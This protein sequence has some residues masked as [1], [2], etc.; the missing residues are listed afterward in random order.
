[1]IY[2]YGLD[3][4]K[5]HAIIIG[6]LMSD[7]I[8]GIDPGKTG[9]FAIAHPGEGEEAKVWKLPM[10][11]EDIISL[12]GDYLVYDAFIEKVHA[13]PKQGVVSTFTFGKEVGKWYGLLEAIG[14]E[15]H[16][17][18]PKTWQ[19]SCIP[20]WIHEAHE[21]PKERSLAAAKWIYPK[22]SDSIGRN[23]NKS[24]SL[25]IATYGM[26]EVDFDKENNKV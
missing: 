9:A 2:Y 11:I 21:S 6:G 19:K 13:M 24:D 5:G 23:H 15:V 4:H 25:L 18:T 10:P 7:Y 3:V 26:N 8:V 17:V 1:L 22:L 16:E 20:K 14:I 12:L